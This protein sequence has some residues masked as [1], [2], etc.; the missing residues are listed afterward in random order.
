M[1]SIED[2]RAKVP[3]KHKLLLVSGKGFHDEMSSFSKALLETGLQHTFLPRPG[4]KHH[5]QS[6]WLEESLKILH[7]D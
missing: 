3:D 5:W 2:F 4:L 6:G 7:A 1:R